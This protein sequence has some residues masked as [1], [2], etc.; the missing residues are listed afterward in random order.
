V[1]PA[2]L[3]APQTGDVFILCRG[4]AVL[5]GTGTAAPSSLG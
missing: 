1:A 2:E 4:P 5:P 3:Q